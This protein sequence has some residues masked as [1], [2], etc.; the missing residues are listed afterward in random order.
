MTKTIENF[1]NTHTELIISGDAV[2]GYSRSLDDWPS[3]CDTRIRNDIGIFNFSGCKCHVSPSRLFS[4]SVKICL[5]KV[6]SNYQLC[7]G[8]RIEEMH[9][10]VNLKMGHKMW[11]A[12]PMIAGGMYPGTRPIERAI[13]F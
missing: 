12:V 13:R 8:G 11:G 4:E 9:A 3:P 1:I 2:D 5:R 7:S 10:T 6:G